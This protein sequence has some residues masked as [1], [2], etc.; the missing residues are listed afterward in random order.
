HHGLTQFLHYSPAAVGQLTASINQLLSQLHETELALWRREAELA[1]GVPVTQRPDESSHLSD[2][3]TEI[4]HTAAD[5]IGGVAAGLYM[6]DEGTVELKLRGAWGLLA[7]RLLK[8]ARPL[9][10]AT[11]DLEALVG[12][13]VLLKD[14]RLVPDW[15]IPED[16][17]A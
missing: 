10:G 9:R 8:S 15:K 1:A 11:A 7:E 4:L 12:H 6:L 17:P 2:R 14:A 3:L 5:L 16:Y 13:A